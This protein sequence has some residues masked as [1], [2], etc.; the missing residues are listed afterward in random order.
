M[1]ARRRNVLDF[2]YGRKII[3]KHC[4]RIFICFYCALLLE[5]LLLSE[6]VYTASDSMDEVMESVNERHSLNTRLIFYTRPS[7]RPAPVTCLTS[8]VFEPM[9]IGR[10]A[11]ENMGQTFERINAWLRVTGIK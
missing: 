9:R 7:S 2:I 6:K 4:S 11:Y 1:I 3:N 10:K 5:F 8:R